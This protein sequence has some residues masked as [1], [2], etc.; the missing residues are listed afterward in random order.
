MSFGKIGKLVDKLGK[1][2]SLQTN[3]CAI[4]ASG[5][6]PALDVGGQLDVARCPLC[7]GPMTPRLCRQGSYYHCLCH[8]R[9]K[10]RQVNGLEEISR[11]ACDAPR[12]GSLVHRQTLPDAAIQ[13]KL[14][15]SCGAPPGAV[16]G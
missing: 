13:N 7:D 8:D 11:L 5:R 6:G 12:A 2:Y 14:L 3:A 9:R 1:I 15:V 16:H 10:Q 4:Q